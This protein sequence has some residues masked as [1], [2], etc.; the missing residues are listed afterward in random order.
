MLCQRNEGIRRL[1]QSL[2]FR[3]DFGQPTGVTRI[4]L[5]HGLGYGDLV[6]RPPV[7]RYA[8]L[9][10]HFCLHLAAVRVLDTL[11]FDDAPR[12][13]FTLVLLQLLEMRLE[14]VKC[15]FD[16]RFSLLMLTEQF[17]T[18]Y[19]CLLLFL[20]FSD[21]LSKILH[22]NLL[23]CLAVRASAFLRD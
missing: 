1:P 11:L 7:L 6:D 19:S 22:P 9:C 21:D 2:R 14:P 20:F 23:R 16:S 3:P 8:H 15:G 12:V 18:D 13:I 17:I 4:E 10:E 5:C